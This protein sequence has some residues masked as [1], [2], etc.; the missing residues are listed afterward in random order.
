MSDVQRI[1]TRVRERG[2]DA[3]DLR[4]AAHEACHALDAGARSWEREDIHA[5]LDAKAKRRRS[6]LW[7]AECLAR[8]VEEVVCDRL[9]VAID[10]RNERVLKACF[11]AVKRRYPFGDYDTTLRQVSVLI[12]DR[13]TLAMVDRILELGA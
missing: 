10:G 12:V 1:I 5:A 9:D 2:S 13:R 4:D 3:R 6:Y 7:E 11:E 8:A